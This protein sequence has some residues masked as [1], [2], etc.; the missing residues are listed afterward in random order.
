MAEKMCPDQNVKEI[1]LMTLAEGRIFILIIKEDNIKL[2]IITH[3][4]INMK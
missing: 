3:L 2:R 1:S 4:R